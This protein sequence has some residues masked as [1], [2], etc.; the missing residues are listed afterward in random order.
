LQPSRE[1]LRRGFTLVELL[2]VITIIGILVSMLLPAV[3]QVREAGRQATC[4]SNIRQLAVAIDLYHNK[5]GVL[6][7]GMWIR[8]ESKPQ[9]PRAVMESKGNLLH[10][11]LPYLDQ[12]N[13]YDLLRFNQVNLPNFTIPGTNIDAY[14]YRIPVF[15]CPSNGGRGIDPGN[16]RALTSYVGSAGPIGLTA[17]GNPDT[18]CKCTN[19]YS[20]F[21]RSRRNA[22]GP[23]PFFNQ[24][25]QTLYRPV[26]HAEIRDGLANTI[27]LGE[28]RWG[29]SDHDRSGWFSSENGCGG[30]STTIPINYDTCNDTQMCSTIPCSSRGNWNTARGFKSA[31]PGGAIFAMGDQS[32]HFFPESIDHQ[33]FQ[34]LGA[35]DDGEAVRVP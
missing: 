29:C 7:I 2:V 21:N 11:L 15:V 4:R 20:S 32:V 17:T 8:Y 34:Y 9:P 5:N 10:R 6:P 22:S 12:Q 3:N 18:P 1:R 24:H 19:P 16:Q 33:L 30:I 31:H 26:S 35:I 28:I 27:F 14:K 25:S 23:G 13:V